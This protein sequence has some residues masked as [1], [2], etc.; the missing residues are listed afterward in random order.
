MNNYILKDYGQIKEYR[1][2]NR[3]LFKIVV[4]IDL[5]LIFLLLWILY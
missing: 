3:T 2:E 5:F 1:K 4:A